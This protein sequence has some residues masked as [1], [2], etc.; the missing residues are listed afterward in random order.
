LNESLGHYALV[1][2]IGRGGMGEVHLAR[3]TR[4]DREVALK[5]LPPDLVDDPDRR[6]RF[7]REA[8]AAAALNH[9]NIT[10]LLDIGEE[11]GRTYIAQEFL[12]GRPLSELVAER[13]LPLAELGALAVPL[14]DALTYAHERGVIHRD[15]KADN[16]MVTAR[17][18]PKL[19][20]FGLAKLSRETEAPGDRKSTTL[21][22]VGAIFGT[23]GA[24]S[25]EQ[26]LGKV[27]DARSDVFSFGSLLYEMACGKP[28]FLGATVQ[29]TLDKILH[30][31]PEPLAQLRR[32]LP[33]DF[34]AIVEKALRKDV[35]E[36]YQSMAELT[37]DLR[38]FK[39]KTDSG[40][41]PP[42]TGVAAPKG[43]QRALH[44]SGAALLL[45]AVAWLA[46]DLL[47]PSGQGE[48]ATPPRLT[49]PRQLTSAVGAEDF[50]S[51]SGQGGLIAY[52]AGSDIDGSGDIDIWITQLGSNTAV[53]R[54]ADIAGNC[55][56]PS[57]SPDG[58]T[59]VFFMADGDRL[60]SYTMPV[61]GGPARPLVAGR[62][63]PW[64]LWGPL[65]WSADGERLA[66]LYWSSEKGWVIRIYRTSG[67]TV[68]ELSLPEDP[69]QAR[70]DLAWSRDE[71]L[72]AFRTT[73]DAAN[74]DTSQLWLLREEDGAYIPL[75]D[76]RTLVRS[77]SF[78]PDGG[79]LHYVSNQGG[80]MDLWRQA[81]DEEGSPVGEPVALTAGLG[82]GRA[83]FSPD[84]NQ[85]AYS[86]GGIVSN[87][88]RVPLGTDEPVGWSDAQQ[89]TYY[90][91]QTEFLDLSHD[92]EWLALTS[93]RS[94]ND[95]IW[96][97]PATGG[98][99]RQL[100][101]NP[102]P[103]GE[104]ILFYSLRSGNRDLWTIPSGGG[105]AR[106]LTDDPATEWFGTWSPD[107]SR[108]AYLNWNDGLRQL[109]IGPL[110]PWTPQPVLT[111][112]PSVSIP[113]VGY[114]W[115][116]DRSLIVTVDGD[117]AVVSDAGEIMRVYEGSGGTIGGTKVRG[118]R[119]IIYK[120]DDQFSTL[121][122]D[123]GERRTVT[124]FSGRPGFLGFPYAAT[125]EQAWFTWS[126]ER[127]DLWVMDV[128]AGK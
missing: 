114:A 58:S 82:I 98:A 105:P 25:P 77:P 26:A 113:T 18:T 122:L 99:M 97:V 52:Q 80:T 126:E 30:A 2:L 15:L 83:V 69:L 128:E 60:G 49:N 121:D 39:R 48:R 4:L 124:D 7:L 21:T 8:R 47:G 10:T 72:F 32:D 123:T 87:V 84:G 31:E 94:G 102:S 46:S 85:I 29:E 34:V 75:T 12:D 93:D 108:I 57:V 96:I 81:L 112:T 79:A 23:P 62:S 42:A 107:G 118:A 5:L 92:G 91:A 86:T 51:W 63:E 104:Q 95:D 67:E 89:V 73:E 74:A 100:T 6:A 103:D 71:R 54:T 65:Q 127:G 28:P 111:S 56:F 106:Q 43:R 11:D 120:L 119:T 68:S 40:L 125:K 19:L 88:W 66:G 90:E 101:T 59:I 50:P 16:V 14:A 38:H 37:A 117:L 35:A 70:A 44:I 45:A 61:L 33:S 3:D 53:N 64:W 13:P 1:R 55:F 22:V 24:M 41:I 27:V 110:E 116:D 36:R 17:G 76:G 115:I 9:P 20:D 78:A 109:M